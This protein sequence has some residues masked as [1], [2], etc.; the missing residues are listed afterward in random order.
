MHL[1]QRRL[2]PADPLPVGLQNRGNRTRPAR[3]LTRFTEHVLSSGHG[4]AGKDDVLNLLA[5]PANPSAAW[6]RPRS[7]FE[8][9]IG[10]INRPFAVDGEVAAETRMDD[11]TA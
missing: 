1:A 11:A 10:R 4:T 7:I 2:Q 8:G 9:G 3:R 5:M 6:Q